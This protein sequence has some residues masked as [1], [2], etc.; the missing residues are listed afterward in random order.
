MLRSTLAR[1]V[2]VNRRRAALVN[3]HL[4]GEERLRGRRSAQRA[5]IDGDAALAEI[6][7]F[8]GQNDRQ[9]ERAGG[10]DGDLELIFFRFELCFLSRVKVG[11][12]DDS[13]P[14]CD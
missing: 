1:H 5:E 14:P 13:K 2:G 4:A 8:V 9:V 12:C 10:G 6:A 7:G 3:V 11:I